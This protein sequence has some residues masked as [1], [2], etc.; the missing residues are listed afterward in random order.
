ME[1][2]DLAGFG[3]RFAARGRGWAGKRSERGEEVEG[4]KGRAPSY[5]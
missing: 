5:C 2:P 1:D 4:G 3:G